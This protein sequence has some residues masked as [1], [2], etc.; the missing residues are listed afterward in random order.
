MNDSFISK[1]D[2]YAYEGS[3]DRLTFSNQLRALQEYVYDLM[4]ETVSEQGMELVNLRIDAKNEALRDVAA[5]IERVAHRLLQVDE[6][7]LADYWNTEPENMKG[8]YGKTGE[9]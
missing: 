2:N 4:E 7:T 9:Q 3:M 6:V 1:H 5:E 8:Q